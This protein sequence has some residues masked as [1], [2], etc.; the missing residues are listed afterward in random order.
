MAGGRSSGTPSG[1]ILANKFFYC[2]NGSNKSRLVGRF[3][4]KRHI[5]IALICSV[6]FLISACSSN[7]ESSFQKIA[8][9]N[10]ST[11]SV[12]VTDKNFGLDIDLENIQNLCDTT[13]FEDDSGKI[14][15]KSAELVSSD[16][17]NLQFEAHGNIEEDL[18]T[19]LTAC[20]Y[21]EGFLQ[22]QISVTSSESAI[23]KYSLQT[24][25]FD[26]FGNRFSIS[27]FLPDQDYTPL[28]TVNLTF[29]ELL[30]ISF[31]KV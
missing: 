16:T 20:A 3:I 13:V 12:F 9:S 27:V 26:D 5:F 25:E 21:D 29:S 15:L 1:F 18:S 23:V 31:T 2:Y 10:F 14:I 6:L 17:I 24:T 8:E 22:S 19:I 11:K 30:L 28:K 7:T 4:L